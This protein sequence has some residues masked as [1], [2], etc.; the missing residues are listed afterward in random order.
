MI[1]Q[2]YQID[3][4][5]GS[6][7]FSVIQNNHTKIADESEGDFLD[8]DLM[9]GA[10]AKILIPISIG[11]DVIGM[12]DIQSIDPDAFESEIIEVFQA[13]AKQLASAVQNFRVIEGT[14]VD[15]QQINQ[16]FLASQTISK[17]VTEDEVYRAVVSGV[18]QT[19]FYSAFYAAHPNG[20]SLL[21]PVESKPYYSDQL[22]TE[23]PLSSRLTYMFFE[24]NE[25]IIIK[26]VSAPLVSIRPELLQPAIALNCT[27]TALLPIIIENNLKG[28]LILAS[29]DAGKI[30]QSAIQPFLAFTNLAVTG[31]EKVVA[32]KNAQQTLKNFETI[33]ELS[34]LIGN[35]TDPEKLYPVIHDQ[36]RNLLG[37]V[38]FYIALYDKHTNYIQIPYLFE[39]EEPLSIDPFPLGEGLTSVVIRTKKPLML[40]ER[41]EERA[42]SLGA[43][44]VGQP[45]K[46]WLGIPLIVTGEVI[47]VISVQDVEHEYRFSNDDLVQLTTLSTAIASSIRSANLLAESE[48]KAF[49]L[50]TVAEISRETSTTLDRGELLKY[51]L[52]L[53]QDRFNF[54][55]AS[56]FIMDPTGEFAVVQESTGDAGKQMKA[57]AHK[58]KVGSQSII[59]YVTENHEPLVVNDVT[60][61]PTHRFN[62]LLPDTRAELGIPI[63]VGK[64]L[65]GALDVQ[66][67]IP[68]A[69]SPD[70][71]EILQILADQLAI[72]MT[73]AD[74]FTET[75]EHLAQHRLIHH[76]TTVAAS[77]TNIEDA[78]SGAVQGL[79][80]TLGDRVSILLKD[81][82]S[83]ELVVQA[84]SGY[85][86][87]VMGMRIEVGQG[88]TGW[89]AEHSEAII[90]ND[91]R[92][93]SRYIAGSEAVQSEMAVPLV[94]RGELLGILNIESD[95]PNA[96]DENDQDILGTLAGSL[97]AIIVNTRLSERQRQL[98]DITSKIRQSVNM[99]TILET[100]ANELTRALQ[101]RRTRIQVGGNLAGITA[102]EQPA[103]IH[104][105]PQAA[106]SSGNGQEGEE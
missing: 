28:L 35:E 41:T 15:L 79:R 32:L 56:V 42:A 70:E 20:L 29:Q 105:G 100:T 24:D 5:P 63:M 55:H 34:N 91:V 60:Q 40:V 87:D 92:S 64:K 102:Q 8:L 65:L 61:D 76:V 51:A 14:E 4:K 12:L 38:D 104:S 83:N 10:K 62:P 11:M 37:D 73:N 99:E 45:A 97:A 84:A 101:T 80:V 54:Y 3:I 22:P 81:P 27:E 68:F 23:I 93:D 19:S 69:F 30:S 39:G 21:Q 75:Q 57:E 86:D 2:G 106:P 9:P 26:D 72:A 36:V 47:G 43:K 7:Y 67:T 52:Q 96:F 59:G 53:I 44:I 66:S 88:I 46:S 18:Q 90:I 95:L 31:L 94:Y 33:N 89:A 85:D 1:S 98:F 103:S 58:L 82:K 78:L 74:L 48:H 71:I 25:P 16:L 6:P 77:S 49:Q 50:Q 13:I 17:A